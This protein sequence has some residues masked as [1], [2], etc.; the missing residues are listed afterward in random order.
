M[1]VA[2]P[3]I[4]QHQ[5]FIIINKPYNLSVH[6]D[7][8]QHSLMDIV[9][10]QVSLPQLWLV[11]RLDKATSGLLILAKHALAAAQLGQLF[12]EHKIEKHYIA[13]SASKPK[14]KQ[15][16]IIGDMVKTRNGNWKLSHQ[17][18]NPAITRF[19]S[20]GCENGLRLFHLLPQTGKTH[21][22]RVAMKSLGSPILGDHRYGSTLSEAI[23][24]TYLHA[25]ALKFN[26]QNQ[27]ILI[28]HFPEEGKYFKQSDIVDKISQFITHSF[29]ES[30]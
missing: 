6:R 17:R 25:Y 15:G 2:I 22:L 12:A 8:N 26:Y 7:D 27:P 14:K 30:I 1:S 9:A 4:Y 13:L 5:D 11:H 18:N 21:Q 10:E 16:L 29:D 20:Y 3:I 23:D 19:Y 28:Q 24:R